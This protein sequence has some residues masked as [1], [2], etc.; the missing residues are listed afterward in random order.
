[1]RSTQHCAQDFAM[2]ICDE[3]LAVI[4]SYDDLVA[5]IRG[6]IVELQVSYETVDNVAGLADHH[7]SKLICGIKRYGLVSLGA[8]LGALGM[9]LVAVEDTEQ[10]ARVRSRLVKRCTSPT[11]RATAVRWPSRDAPVKAGDESS[12]HTGPSQN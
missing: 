5:V 4:R 3:P 11:V 10:L 1:L 9:V 2:P 6:R 7:T 8:T 12:Q